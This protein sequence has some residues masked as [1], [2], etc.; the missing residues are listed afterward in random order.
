MIEEGPEE[1]EQSQKQSMISRL[2][3]VEHQPAGHSA[4]VDLLSRKL[5]I[6]RCKPGTA[7]LQG[8]QMVSS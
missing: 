8:N 2:N 1:L 3:E 7:P 5:V 4:G 6:G